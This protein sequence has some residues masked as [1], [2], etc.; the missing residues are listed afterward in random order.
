MGLSLVTANRSW[1]SPENMPKLPSSGFREE[2]IFPLVVLTCE[3]LVSYLLAIPDLLSAVL[4][5]YLSVIYI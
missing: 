4:S 3:C 2:G 1:L 5:I